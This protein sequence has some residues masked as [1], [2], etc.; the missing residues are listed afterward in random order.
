MKADGSVLDD[1]PWPTLVLDK[2][3]AVC[4][5]NKSAQSIFGSPATSPGSPLKTIWSLENSR[6]V[7]QFLTNGSAKASSPHDAGS[8]PTIVRLLGS[9]GGAQNY[10][11]SLFAVE[12]SGQQLL[13]VQFFDANGIG[14]EGKPE[15]AETGSWPKQKFDW[16]LQLA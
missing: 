15:T 14:A 4:R 9:N 13:L 12:E 1:A 3:G 11:A 6:S 16:A 2:A 10:L 5:A 8:A 7:E